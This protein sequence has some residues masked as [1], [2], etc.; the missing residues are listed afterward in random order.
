MSI[1]DTQT[2]FDKAVPRPTPTNFHTQ[3]GCHFEEVAEMVATL[4]PLDPAT[5]Y[6]LDRAKDTLEALAEHLKGGT[7]LIM[8][9]PTDRVEL[10]DALC[11]Q[12]VTAVGVAHMT[13][14]DIVGGL[15]EVNRSNF[16][17][18][19]A[20]GNPIFAGNNKITKGPSYRAPDL[21]D[22]AV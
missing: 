7:E 15:H 3:L 18:F 11:D 6:V 1:A 9:H 10:L 17:K 16:S 13:E 14:M 20:D 4:T 8:L 2:W 19:D 21:T 5:R 22:F 12:I